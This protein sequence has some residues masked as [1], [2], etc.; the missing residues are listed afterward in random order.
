[1]RTSSW[2]GM[3]KGGSALETLENS[4]LMDASRSLV[5]DTPP[6][7]FVCWWADKWVES[8][9]NTCFPDRKKDL[10]KLQAGEYV[11][12]GKVEA[13]LKNCP[14]V[15]NICAYAN[16]YY[17]FHVPSFH[18]LLFPRWEDVLIIKQECPFFIYL[19]IFFSAESYVIS[20][21]V[22]NHKQLMALARQLQINGAWEEIC[23][24]PQIE[25]EFLR[26]ITDAAVSGRNA[27]VLLLTK[28]L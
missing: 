15:D 11:S 18:F 1:M 6:D 16:R 24:N 20:F 14:Y 26:I 21:V 28:R 5:G 10:V 12:L 2:M 3:A 17:P 22:P 9:V 25:K 13:I 27:V 4:T 8:N 7:V 19:F 23:N